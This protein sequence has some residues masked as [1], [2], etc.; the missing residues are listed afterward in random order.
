MA[1]ITAFIA[2][3]PDADPEKHRCLIETEMTKQYSI[4]VANQTQAIEQCKKLVDNDGV[5]LIYLCP[6]FNNVQ[7]GEI[8]NAA[9]NRVAVTVARGDGPSTRLYS[10]IIKKE[11]WIK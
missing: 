9:G 7:V 1:F 4:L 3:L 5:Q 8:A 11:G 10:E 6:A 2:R